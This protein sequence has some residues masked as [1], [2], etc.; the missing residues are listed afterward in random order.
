MSVPKQ[1]KTHSKTRM[2]RAHKKL[3]KVQGTVCSH[4]KKPVLAH[5]VCAACGYYKGRQV[6]RTKEEV[7]TK[8]EVKKKAKEDKAKA[9]K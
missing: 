2:G 4:C 6:I 9:K 1:R 3:K 5:Q 7:I 8:R